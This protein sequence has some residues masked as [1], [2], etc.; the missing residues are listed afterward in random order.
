MAVSPYR[1]QQQQ[2]VFHLAPEPQRSNNLKVNTSSM[3]SGP[4]AGPL[5]SGSLSASTSAASSIEMGGGAGVV[6]S[7]TAPLPS[8][9][10]PSQLMFSQGQVILT[11][12]CGQSPITYPIPLKSVPLQNGYM[13]G[14]FLIFKQ[15]KNRSKIDFKAHKPTWKTHPRPSIVTIHRPVHRLKKRL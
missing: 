3:V 6:T 12:V 14:I 15:K 5:G 8:Q 11:G 9:P 7:S 2:P 4:G 10:P 13:H 1:L